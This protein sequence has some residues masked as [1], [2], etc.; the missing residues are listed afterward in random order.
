MN[1]CT[2]ME[3]ENPNLRKS[4]Q[5]QGDA[6]S[7]E[8]NQVSPT[9]NSSEAGLAIV[10]TGEEQ[11]T[12]ASPRKIRGRLDPSQDG[13]DR[14]H[15]ASKID[16]YDQGNL[17][18]SDHASK[19]SDYT[20]I[21]DDLPADTREPLETDSELNIDFR[22]GTGART[23]KQLHEIRTQVPDALNDVTKHKMHKFSLYETRTRYYLV[24][25]DLG[26]NNFR[27]LKI[28]R[29][30]PP[31]QLNIVEDDVI[32]TKQQM[33]ELLITIEQGNQ[34]VGGMKLRGNTWGLL[35]F[36]R[37][38]E[39][40]YMCMIT[41]K[42]PVAM[43]GG[44]YIYQV[45]N[46][47]L[48]PLTTGQSAKYMSNRNAEEQ[49]FLGILHNLDLH[50][51]FYFSNSYNV[52][53]TLQHNVIRARQKPVTGKQNVNSGDFNDMFVWNHHLLDPALKYMKRPHDWCMPIIH[54][55][56]DQA[57]VDVFGRNIWITLIARRSRF[58][59]GARFLKRG[60]NDLGYCANDVETE[61]IVAGMRTTS[62]DAP[63]QG[64]LKN[65][66]YTS[67]V[68]HRGSI[69]LYWTQ[70]NTG[71][72]P[73]PG[74]ELNFIDPFYAAAALHF[75]NLFERYGTPITVVNLVRSRERTPREVKL[76]YEYQ[77]AIVYLNQSLPEGKKILYRAFDMARAAKNPHQDVIASLE[78]IASDLVRS[79][80]FFHNGIEQS[81]EGIC[82]QNGAA[83]SNC[84]DCLDRT[85]ACQF[86]IGK[87]AFA[88]Q[89]QALGV[90]AGD[91]VNYDSD[92]TNLLAHMYNDHGDTL[93]SQY[94][95]SHLVNTTDS[96]RKIGNWQSH[97]R[98]ML[99]S[100]K[101]YY[102]NS[103]L[104]SQRQEAY[105]LFLG[106]YRYASGQPM[107]WELPSDYYL[108]HTT[109]K[110]FAGLV[111]RS[112]I[113]WF[114]PEHLERRKMPPYNDNVE[115]EHANDNAYDSEWWH[116]YYKPGSYSSFAKAFSYRIN[117]N[118]K[119]LP[120]LGSE[121]MDR[122]PFTVRRNLHEHD[123]P[124]RQPHEDEVGFTD[125][126]SRKAIN[127]LS[128]T[129]PPQMNTNR[130]TSL[131]Q[132][133]KGD[134]EALGSHAYVL[135][136]GI[137]KTVNP[138][139]ISTEFTPADKNMMKQWTV[140]QFYDNSLHPTVTDEEYRFYERSLS[141][142]LNVPLATSE[143]T[144]PD[145]AA[146]ENTEY[147]AKLADIANFDSDEGTMAGI[148]E[149]HRWATEENPLIVNADDFEKKRFQAYA[150][151]LRGKSLFKQAKVD[152]EYSQGP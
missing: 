136:E 3:E 14:S 105:N 81:D 34:G 45:E 143:S 125:V 73:K 43:I 121:T 103:F 118:T 57:S 145:F 1:D 56:I 8:L 12:A 32:Y 65:P 141:E 113:Q 152:P 75:D 124:H 135:D 71:V 108:H 87:T 107:L 102:H 120:K 90:I 62:L 149:Y 76:L 72:T 63:G 41:G 97:S 131:Q 33:S 22:G 92:A 101:R 31:G 130:I 25:G 49:R 94:G 138:P 48:V 93:A 27:V 61:Q 139:V 37:F 52:T 29:T 88:L 59:A 19:H 128:A 68:Q 80:G 30:A 83:R 26:D 116:E 147:I 21:D 28:D 146:G 6:S 70:D 137:D 140:R 4:Q 20:S 99:E 132:W 95:G 144:L 5:Q 13:G 47:E 35:G 18:T 9:G 122:S 51:C 50:R 117:S 151:W 67:F 127:P 7:E 69:P 148:A 74:I 60:V 109:P 114:T 16:F 42:Q 142:N 133:L 119:Y 104:D 58:F 10:I 24:G 66:S 23:P 96:Y 106:N 2:P 123:M 17:V 11:H 126:N 134:K 129:A 98:D 84:I 46:T 77:N 36:I 55:F 39:A 79:T 150:K 100:F 115:R 82:I 54:G 78:T 111:R 85:N 44:H 53:R 38:T 91:N 112:Y 86:V 89:L 110:A 40:Y 15:D 64:V